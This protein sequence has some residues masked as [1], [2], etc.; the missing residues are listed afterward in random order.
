MGKT[1]AILN[2]VDMVNRKG[3]YA[4][5]ADLSTASTPLDMGNR[6]LAAA[7][8]VF[9]KKWRN[10]IT[11]IVSR[12]NVTVSLRPDSFTGI[13]IPSVDISLRGDDSTKQRRT[14][15]TVLDSINETAGERRITVGIALDEFQE[16][17]KFGGETAE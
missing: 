14:L 2:A 17:H 13:P 9:G 3:G 7:S 10:F 15:T 11:D 5:L 1:S 12:L 6:I 8:R 16:I 4:F